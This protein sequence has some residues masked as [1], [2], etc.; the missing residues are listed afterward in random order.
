MIKFCL[1]TLIFA[2]VLTGIISV[3]IALP[4]TPIVKQSLL[5]SQI[6]KDSL[7]LNEESPRIIFVGGS[8]LSFGLNS[9]EIRD[10]LCLNPINTAVHAGIGL[11]YMIDN[12]FQY[13][14]KGDIVVLIPEYYHFYRDYNGGSE[15]LLRTLLEVKPSNIK[16]LNIN[17]IVN[18][19]PFL[20]KTIR[21]KLNIL[22]Y[23]N[24]K[25]DINNA[26]SVNSFNKYGDAYVHW[27]KDSKLFSPN[28]KI[29]TIAYNPKVI[30]LIKIM[31]EK[32]I[33]KG[34]ILYVAFPAFQETSFNRSVDAIKIVEAEYI[35]NNFLI[36]GNAE[37]YR[38]PDSLM[39]DTPYHC[40]KKGVDLR[41][42][43]IIE[44]LKLIL[45]K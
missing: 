34:C 25:L 14:K 15:E 12:T 30:E 9:Q 6:K 11:K 3:T 29:D 7:L 44:D 31:E 45:N 13:C 28:E 16:L 4:V 24:V 36:L 33:Q 41:T 17:Q 22:A 26:Y 27:A 18:S 1:K 19:M 43:Y 39:F 10:S 21:S 35:E 32:L 37:R 23:F 20:G 42:R 2:V 38:M 40:N 5:F 8:N